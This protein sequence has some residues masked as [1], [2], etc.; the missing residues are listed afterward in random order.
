M[1]NKASAYQCS[2]SRAKQRALLFSRPKS[3][4]AIRRHDRPSPGFVLSLQT[5]CATVA[6]LQWLQWLPRCSAALRVHSLV[7]MY[8]GIGD[9]GM[10]YYH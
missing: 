10:F 9:N 6:M 7:I 4:I 1:R 8:Y 2:R 3:F 5:A